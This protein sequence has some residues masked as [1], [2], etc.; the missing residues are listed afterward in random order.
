[1]VAKGHKMAGWV[2]RT[3]KSRATPVMKTLL[4]SIIISHV[5]Y[6]S[7]VWSPTD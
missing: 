5:E 4:Q 1:M 6:A 7:V 2:L 3:F